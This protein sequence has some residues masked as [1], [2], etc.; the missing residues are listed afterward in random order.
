MATNS[1]R[2]D[3]DV[4]R[5]ATEIAAQLGLTYNAIINVFLREFI[6]EK[7]FPFQVKLTAEEKDVFKMSTK[8]ITEAVQKSIAERSDVTQMPYTTV[9]NDQGQILKVF[10]DGHREAL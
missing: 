2:V 9:M 8:E 7:G 3:D 6:R 1:I 5:E 10:Q 4:K